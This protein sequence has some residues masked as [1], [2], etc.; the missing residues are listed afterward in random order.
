V[1]ESPPL[2]AAGPRF[3]GMPQAAMGQP[4]IVGNGMIIVDGVPIMV[5]PMNG[6]MDEPPLL[7][8]ALSVKMRR[9]STIVQYFTFLSVLLASCMC[10]TSV[11]YSFW[12]LPKDNDDAPEFDGFLEYS[13]GIIGGAILTFLTS[14]TLWSTGCCASQSSPEVIAAR[15]NG[16]TWALWHR[17]AFRNVQILNSAIS[18]LIALWATVG[19]CC[20]FCACSIIYLPCWFGMIISTLQL[21]VHDISRWLLHHLDRNQYPRPAQVAPFHPAVVVS[22]PV[23][24]QLQQQR[25]IVDQPSPP[26]LPSPSPSPLPHHVI[27]ISPVAS[28]VADQHDVNNNNANNNNNNNNMAIAV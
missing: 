12:Y 18:C 17:S 28:P 10:L 3:A 8:D 6:E 14:I 13:P 19:T 27:G 16:D 5:S 9:I 26:V 22:G 4:V 25:P 11:I 15:A 1:P 23:A 2:V 24:P 7:M 21:Y 20:S